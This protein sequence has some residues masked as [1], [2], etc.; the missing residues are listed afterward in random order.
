MKTTTTLTR[1]FASALVLATAGLI[2]AG[3]GADSQPGY[4]P[5]MMMQGQP[6]GGYGPGMMGGYGTGMMGGYGPGMM[7][8]GMGMMGGGMGMMGFWSLN[9]SKEQRAK[10]NQISDETRR[11]HWELM[12]KMQEQSGALRDLYDADKRDAAEIGKAYQKIF[13]LKRQMIETSVD[14]HNRMEAVLTKEQREQLR[15][16]WPRGGMMWQEP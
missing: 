8:G 10:I 14:A 16:S 3:A 6:S 13:D 9:L 2:S 7:G 11:K 12:G 4:P 15:K 5:G 1:R